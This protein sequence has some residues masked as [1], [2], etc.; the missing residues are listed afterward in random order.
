MYPASFRSSSL[1]SRVALKS[2]LLLPWFLSHDS[3]HSNL[4]FAHDKRCQ[5]IRKLDLFTLSHVGSCL[6]ESLPYLIIHCSHVKIPLNGYV[7]SDW[8]SMRRPELRQFNADW[9]QVRGKNERK[10][11]LLCR[12]KECGKCVKNVAQWSQLVFYP[13][14]HPSLSVQYQAM[15]VICSRSYKVGKILSFVSV[16]FV[17]FR[18]L[19]I[20]AKFLRS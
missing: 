18:F 4:S 6:Y 8:Q 19:L 20:F 11:N 10:Q 2:L 12:V 15:L 13:S 5:K 1:Q 7:I 14:F 17:A 9:Y 3:W 16:A